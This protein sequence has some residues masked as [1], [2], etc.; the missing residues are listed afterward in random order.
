MAATV[1]ELEQRVQW[2]A[3]KLE[4]VTGTSMNIPVAIKKE[5]LAMTA[6]RAFTTLCSYAGK[7]EEFEDWKFQTTAFLEEESIF[8]AILEWIDAEDNVINYERWDEFCKA[9][10]IEGETASWVNAQLFQVL[11]LKCRGDALLMVKNIAKDT[12]KKLVRGLC[13]WQKLIKEKTGMTAQ[14]C[15]GLLGRIFNPDRCKK[16]SDVVSALELWEVRL[17]EYEIFVKQPLPPIAKNYAVKRLVPV[18][19]E[20]DIGRMGGSLEDYEKTK[21]YV[22][23]QVTSRKEVWF[24]GEE[25][26]SN[27]G[28]VPM[29]IGH[30]GKAQN[31]QEEPDQEEEGE[32][33]G[34]DGSLNTMRAGG[35]GG[36]KFWGNCHHCG[37]PGHRISECRLKDEQMAKMR[38][39]EGQGGK[40]DRK[41]TGGSQ[42]G[43]N[44]K[45]QGY[46]GGWSQT[47]GG[48]SQGS[49][50]GYQPKGKGK[51]GQVGKGMYWF[52]SPPGLPTDGWQAA[53]GGNG[54]LFTL[55]SRMPKTEVKNQFAAL[56]TEDEE[57]DE[58]EI[59]M[60]CVECN[61]GCEENRSE[62]F[63]APLIAEEMPTALHHINEKN[64]MA[65]D[66]HTGWRR[67]RSVVDSGASESCAPPDI[68]PEVETKES[69][70][71]R[72]GQ[73]Y[74]G[75]VAGAKVIKNLGEK[76]LGMFTDEGMPTAGTWQI[77][78]VQRPLSSV[79]QICRQ[80]NRVIFGMYGGVIQSMETGTEVPF[81]VEDNI[82]TLDLW[83]PPE[84]MK[85]AAGEGSVFAG[86]G[87][88]R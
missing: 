71:S 48:W 62:G 32:P 49:W 22:M 54:R 80:G 44:A 73:T 74:S 35:K 39:G 15:H 10:S 29:D 75:A 6:R 31:G 28:V 16:Y 37:K 58:C 60:A 21:R 38:K 20:K 68:A 85:G 4:A 26:N 69:E 34:E 83:M 57:D 67:V 47:K 8:G 65:V 64:W 52:D 84:G 30:M 59:P 77:L 72:R 76:E 19:L 3:S 46:G 5:P 56:G 70:G 50:P 33:D 27:N 2:L 18:E 9:N 7:P 13:A 55:D 43:W 53:G 63:V 78:D 86:Q 24:S 41:G 42:G 12:E 14:R 87:W 81:G 40:G 1:A 25:K 88:G 11:S 36:G 66:P 82:Y 51:G 79:R 61:A 17:R 23:E 45:G